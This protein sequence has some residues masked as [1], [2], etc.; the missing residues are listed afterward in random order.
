MAYRWLAV[1]D[2]SNKFSVVSIC[3]PETTFADHI[4]LKKTLYH[5]R[6]GTLNEVPEGRKESQFSQSI[7]TIIND[8]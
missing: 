4:V 6:E 7:G 8:V 1:D 2:F 3:T 5:I